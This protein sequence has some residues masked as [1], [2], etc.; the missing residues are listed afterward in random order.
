[1]S[2]FAVD[3]DGD[4]C[5]A[6]LENVNVFRRACG[7]PLIGEKQIRVVKPNNNA[8]L[9]DHKAQLLRRIG[10]AQSELGRLNKLF[11]EIRADVLHLTTE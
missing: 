11:D 8:I 5:A 2:N 3:R 10:N 9:P 1:V 6:P 4:D 7:L